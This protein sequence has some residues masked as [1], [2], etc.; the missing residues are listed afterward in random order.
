VTLAKT[1]LGIGPQNGGGRKKDQLELAQKGQKS[2]GTSK[3]KKKRF[4]GGELGGGKLNLGGES[5]MV[6]EKDTNR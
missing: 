2:I 3:K 1:F 5:L 4:W 6:R